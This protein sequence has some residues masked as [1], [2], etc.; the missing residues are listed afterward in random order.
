METIGHILNAV[1]GLGFLVCFIIVLVKMFQNGHTVL[2]I[3]CIICCGIGGLVAF[4]YGWVKSSEWGIQNVM[5]IWT[6]CFILTIIGGV[7]APADLS[8]IPGR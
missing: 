5:I 1:G 8:Q 2:G 3:V 4:I 7:L 6:I